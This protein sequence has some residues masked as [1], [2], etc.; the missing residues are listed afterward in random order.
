LLNF[1]SLDIMKPRGRRDSSLRH[2]PVSVLKEG[3]EFMASLRK[4]GRVWY[5]RFTDADGV[6]R[7]RKGCTDKRATEELAHEAESEAA[8]IKAGLVDPKALRIAEANREPI[9]AHLDAFLASLTQAG[10]K[11][12]HVNNTRAA[13]NR[14]L[15]LAKIRRLPD[16]TPSAIVPALARLKDQGFAPRTVEAHII[17]VK[18]FSRWAWR[19]GRAA[20]YALVGLVKPGG[21][22][23]RR[24]VRRALT[25][26]ELQMLVETTKGAPPWRRL[27]GQDRSLLYAIASMT[28]FR[29]GELMSLTPESFRLDA[30]PP[31]IVCEAGYTKNGRLA[32]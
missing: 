23:E 9:E 22:M 4:R 12:K 32:E 1:A 19:D 24:R 2:A 15:S 5:Y 6:K 10:R 11:A 28:G 27:S 8:K 14:V 13:I 16:L 25:D 26:A 7:E 3:D 18:S 21:P 17:A 30:K 29:R 31:T 20:D